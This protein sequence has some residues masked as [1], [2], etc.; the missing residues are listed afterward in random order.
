MAVAIHR[1]TLLPLPISPHDVLGA[2]AAV[3]HAAREDRQTSEGHGAAHSEPM[4][5]SPTQADVVQ[6]AAPAGMGP[7]QPWW[8]MW[9]AFCW[10]NRADW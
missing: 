8:G 3:A 7:Y 9:C 6:E 2:A 10:S 4:A 1:C 5:V